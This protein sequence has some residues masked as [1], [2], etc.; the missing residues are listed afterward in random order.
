ML[1]LWIIAS[2]HIIHTETACADPEMP[3]ISQILKQIQMMFSLFI[4]TIN[5]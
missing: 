4:H 3:F 5:I 1:Y 2:A